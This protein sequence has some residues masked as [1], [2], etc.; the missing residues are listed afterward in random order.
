[1]RKLRKGTRVTW[2]W[3]AHTGEGKVAESFTRDVSR[4]IK[5]TEVKRKASPDE[6]AYLVEQADGDHVLKSHS[7]LKRAD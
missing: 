6:P 5:G 7:E 3:G 2:A 4:Q 1:M